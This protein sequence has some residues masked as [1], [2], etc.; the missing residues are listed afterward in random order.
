MAN[1]P[2][3]P[4]Q[5]SLIELDEQSTARRDPFYMAKSW[6]LWLLD[7][8][9]KAVQAAPQI[10]TTVPLQAQHATI[11]ATAIPLGSV[12][13]GLFRVS[14]YARI[15]SPDGVG[16]SLTVTL[17]WTESAVA[18]SLSGA[19]MTGDTTT[20]VQSGTVLIQG[21]AAAA[22]SYATTYAS[23]TPAKMQYRL[24]VVVERVG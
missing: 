22:I 24:T 11:G 16:S 10:L 2:G 3:P 23:T 4:F 20:T 9:L 13:A 14:Y 5:D 12:T 6:L 15:T 21:D 8:L 17:S 7:S 1:L 18:L 19:A